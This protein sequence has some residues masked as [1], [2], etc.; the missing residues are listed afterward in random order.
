VPKQVVVLGGGFAGLWSAVGAARKLDE[1]GVGADAVQVTLVNAGAYHC[2]RVRNYERDLRPVRVAL[3][4]VLGPIGV[5]RVDGHVTAID[6]AQR[7][8]AVQTAAGARRLPYD[9]LVLATG[10][11]LVRPALPGLA[12]HAFSVDT[13]AEAMR[14]Q[15]H[16]EALA[17]RPAA[18]GRWTALVVGAGLTGIEIGC[19]LPGRLREIVAPQ[20]AAAPEEIRVILADHAGHV[21]SDMGASARPV[22]DE[23]LASL[24]IETRLAVRVEAVEPGDVTLAGGEHLATYTTIWTAGMRASPLTAQLPVE[25]DRFG[26][27]PV[28]SYMKVKGLDGVFAAGDVAW[29]MLDDTHPS[30]M[31][32]QHGRP[33]G[34]FAGHN[35][36]CDLLGEAPLPLRIDWYVTILDLGPWGAIYTEGWERT[37]TAQGAV[38]K[39]VKREINGHRI[40][41]PQSGDRREILAAAAPVVQAPPALAR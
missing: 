39:A 20:A 30:V 22:I 40:Y 41:P 14:L 32:C 7:T 17:Q 12:E 4:Q 26:R 11:Q 35:V 38:A 23:A 28:D 5:G 9:R 34:R 8:V 33:M 2:I 31:S 21:G 15:A 1:L 19:E 3:D 16:L 36:I 6:P 13:Y 25:R 10:S 18:P 37:V 27:L 29:A 24:G